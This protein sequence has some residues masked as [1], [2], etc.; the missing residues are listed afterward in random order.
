MKNNFSLKFKIFDVFIIAF[1]VVCIVIG[2]IYSS[3]SFAKKFDD[4]CI[5][6]ICHGNDVLME[7]NME[8]VDGEMEIVLTKEEYP[9]LLGDF[10]VLINDTYGVCV[11][12]ITCPNHACEKMGWID[13]LNFPVTCL[14]NNM[15]VRIESKDV[16]VDIPMG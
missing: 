3:I 14:P 6:K 10:T 13:S 8:D 12:N 7:V 4:D 2:I 16:D 5:V 1:S 9:F 15:F 11:T